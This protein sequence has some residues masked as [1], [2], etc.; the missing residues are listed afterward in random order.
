MFTGKGACELC[1]VFCY[2]VV[3]IKNFL[4]AD[5]HL[6]S[7]AKSFVVVVGFFLKYSLRR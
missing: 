1:S 4:A 6:D 3:K 7:C 2:A 5:D